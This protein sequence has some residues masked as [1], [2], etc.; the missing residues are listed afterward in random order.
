MSNTTIDK[1][2]QF[3]NN[4]KNLVDEIFNDNSLSKYDKLK[5]ISENKL[6][7]Y[8]TFK[9][10][11]SFGF[12]EEK[13]IKDNKLSYLITDDYFEMLECARHEIVDYFETIEY[14][15]IGIGEDE[16]YGDILVLKSRGEPVV[17][18]SI[19][20]DNFVDYIYET[21]VESGYIGFHNDW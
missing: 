2:L 21:V 5:L 15:Y 16:F 8:D 14:L 20:I 10:H 12:D 13:Y 3:N 7:P 19:S 17:E 6:L 18:F 11:H 1:V 9:T 4:K